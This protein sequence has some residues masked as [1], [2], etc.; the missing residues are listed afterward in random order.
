MISFFGVCSEC[1]DEVEALCDGD[2]PITCP[3]CR[4]IDSVEE[5][6]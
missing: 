3:S 5:Q 4:S 2:N 1:Q 6:E